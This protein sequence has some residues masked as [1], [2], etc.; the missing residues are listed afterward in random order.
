MKYF[1]IF[2][3]CFLSLSSFSQD[4]ELKDLGEF[5]AKGPTAD[6]LGISYDEDVIYTTSNKGVN[7]KGGYYKLLKVIDLNTGELLSEEKLSKSPKLKKK[8]C[9]YA[10]FTFL[11][12]KPTLLCSNT[13]SKNKEAEISGYEVDKNL[14]FVSSKPTII[15]KYN[16]CSE[17][18]NNMPVGG[19]EKTS[20]FKLDNGEVLLATNYTCQK[21]SNDDQKVFINRLSSKNEVVEN[22]EIKL[23]LP[24]IKNLDIIELDNQIFLSVFTIKDHNTKKT[25]R[26]HLFKV[27]SS[28]EIDKI[29]IDFNISSSELGPFRFA[30]AD[31]KI[32][33][34]GQLLNLENEALEGVFSA[35]FN[36]KSKTIEN[37]EQ[38]IFKEDFLRRYMSKREVKKDKRKGTKRTSQFMNEFLPKYFFN[39][40]D[41]GAISIHQKHRMNPV[42]NMTLLF[43]YDEIL[44][45][46]TNVNGSIEWVEYLPTN[47]SNPDYDLFKG[48]AIMQ[49]GSYIY[50]AHKASDEMVQMINQSSHGV[51]KS[52]D[53]DKVAITKIKQ[54][55]KIN[56]KT[57]LNLDDHNVNYSPDEIATDYKN[58][59]FIFTMSSSRAFTPNK[60]KVFEL[61]I[62][63]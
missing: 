39:T 15:T 58:K 54:N 49:L 44:V 12:N 35:L 1:L 62:Q 61:L 17:M 47:F 55:G 59:K 21:K 11:N 57:V 24:F 48:F 7:I 2:L 4:Y 40:P 23:D 18:W 52:K 8:K 60:T 56:S 43:S 32:V 30:K 20:V 25:P 14:N 22:F 9:Y 51:I 46:K 29:E 45:V 63:Q 42:Q 5:K 33:F 10:G 50:I 41:G 36:P 3:V 38:K 37:F 28:G 13:D 34:S 6:F 26:S 27:N 16:R 19:M 31:D 53:L